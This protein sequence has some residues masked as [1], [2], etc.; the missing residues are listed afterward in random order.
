ME[1]FFLAEVKHQN[2]FSCYIWSF[3]FLLFRL[4]YGPGVEHSQRSFF[5]PF[6]I[7]LVC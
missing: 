5:L 4:A 7:F 6:E 2:Y 1:L 3:S